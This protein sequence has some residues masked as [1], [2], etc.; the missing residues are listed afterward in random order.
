MLDL[1]AQLQEMEER[2]LRACGPPRA[3]AVQ[4]SPS[5]CPIHRVRG[6]GILRFAL[7]VFSEA[8]PRRMHRTT[9]AGIMIALTQG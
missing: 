7:Q 5:S 3:R 4:L 2:G 6:I 8:V 1:V 9:L